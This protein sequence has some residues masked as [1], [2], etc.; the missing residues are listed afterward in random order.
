MLHRDAV[1]LCL[2]NQHGEN[3]S[4]SFAQASVP[5][6]TLAASP[7][8]PLLDALPVIGAALARRPLEKDSYEEG[9]QTVRSD[10][11]GGL[12]VWDAQLARHADGARAR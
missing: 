10:V 11:A 7:L 5:R 4:R 6:D 1:G 8:G 2:H 3:C 12:F 9:G